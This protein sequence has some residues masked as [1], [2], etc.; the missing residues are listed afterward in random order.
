MVRTGVQAQERIS[1]SQPLHL[2]VWEDLCWDWSSSRADPKASLMPKDLRALY[3][4][5]RKVFYVT[6]A[7]SEHLTAVSVRLL[8]EKQASL[9]PSFFSFRHIRYTEVH[10]AVDIALFFF[11]QYLSK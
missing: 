1:C 8:P 4:L 2:S 11:S 9:G 7:V 3:G 6:V 5:N 10:G